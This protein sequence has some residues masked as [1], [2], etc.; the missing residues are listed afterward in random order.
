MKSSKVSIITPCFNAQKYLDQM[1]SSVIFQTHKKW[2][3]IIVDDYST[4]NSVK[5]IKKFI[6]KDSRIKLLKLKKRSG[7]ALARNKAIN[8]AKGRY[9]AFLDADDYWGI[10][11]LK[12]SLNNINNN[13]LIYSDYNKVNEN[14]EYIHRF[15]ASPT[16]N[17]NGIFKG[18]P[19]SC[20]TAFI[21]IK[22]FGKKLFPVN[23]N[24]ED[25]AYWSLILK[26]C[27]IAYGFRFCEA[28][29]RYR[30]DSSSANKIKMAFQTWQDYR[31]YYN[32]P[33]L[34]SFYFFFFYAINACTKFFSFYFYC[35]CLKLFKIQITKKHQN[36]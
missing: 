36:F 32:L 8:F 34:K 10:N 26:E 25:I 5:I 2:E 11:F 7:P 6:K 18:T 15:F 27:K 20:L 35:I 29:C 23:A 17:Y 1:I 13:V 22:K 24:R 12:Y 21:D 19:I 28:N 33:F 4:D 3:L 9:L 30:K 16:V 31:N 14:G